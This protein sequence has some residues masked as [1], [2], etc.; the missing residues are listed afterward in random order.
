[1]PIPCSSNPLGACATYDL[2]PNVEVYA[3]SWQCNGIIFTAS[4]T[5]TAST[6]DI[7]V[8]SITRNG[9]EEAITRKPRLQSITLT[10]TSGAT[11]GTTTNV[12]LGIVDADGVLL[13]MSD[14]GFPGSKAAT[15]RW[16]FGKVPPLDVEEPYRAV[17]IK[18]SVARDLNVGDEITS[19]ELQRVKLGQKGVANFGGAYLT[20]TQDNLNFLGNNTR[21]TLDIVG[22][23]QHV[24]NAVITFTKY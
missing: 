21:L 13:G 14:N 23:T 24:P 4:R 16:L 22:S 6:L 18:E 9:K 10:L 8:V 2:R 15:N 20:A 11:G 5:A 12:R 19:A 17:F 7:P 3:S 1:M